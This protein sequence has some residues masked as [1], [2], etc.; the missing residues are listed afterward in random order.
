MVRLE[1]RVCI[2]PIGPWCWLG[3]Q[4]GTDDFDPSQSERE[5]R[6]T[7][8]PPREQT[9]EW[10]ARIEMRQSELLKTTNHSRA[11]CF[12]RSRTISRPHRLKK[13]SSMQSK[14]RGLHLTTSWDKRKI[15]F[16]LTF[17]PRNKF[18]TL[19]IQD[20]CWL[21]AIHFSVGPLGKFEAKSR[22]CWCY[23]S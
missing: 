18:L 12:I 9:T 3:N 10:T 13:T 14:R 19:N 1:D 23:L 7:N 16:L 6:A 8:G 2:I 20:F 5:S 4:S 21:V 17:N 15:Y 22:P 11:S